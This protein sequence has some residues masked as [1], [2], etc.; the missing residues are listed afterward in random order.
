[1]S[2]SIEDEGTSH[3]LVGKSALITGGSRGIGAAISKSLAKRGANVVINYF[4]NDASA[5]AV[6][7]EI[8]TSK[9]SD[10]LV[11]NAI[12]VRADVTNAE[13]VGR[14]MVKIKEIFD[15]I[16][17]VV[18]NAM[19]GRY[20][21]KPFLELKWDDLKKKFFDEIKAAYEITKATLPSM[22]QHNYGRIVY[23]ASANAKYPIPPDAIAFGTAKAGLV[24]FAK[25]IAQTYGRNGI[26]ANI[27]SP[28][29]ID[30]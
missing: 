22:I 14:M 2:N 7:S 1:M 28:G 25:Y 15:H 29:L 24:A 12:A 19:I 17:I 27:L 6:L 4:N 11:G 9:D 26:T 5:S 10:R 30:E 3:I 13:D 20:Y 23:I 18:N 8:N 21:L 16:D